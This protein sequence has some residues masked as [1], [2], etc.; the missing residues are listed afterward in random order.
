MVAI[1][2]F[3]A[4]EYGLYQTTAVSKGIDI[5]GTDPFMRLVRV[6]ELHENG[7]WYDSTID[8]SNAPYGDELHW[9]RP[10]DLILHL[11]ALAGSMFVPY[12][13]ALYNVGI[14]ISVIL[15]CFCLCIILWMPGNTLQFEERPLMLLVF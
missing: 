9:T 4:I 7:S 5:M 11:P 8:R 10:L 1:L 2:A 3:A 13:V 6:E 12:D 14:W 15:G